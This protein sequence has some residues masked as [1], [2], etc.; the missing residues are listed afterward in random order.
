MM[1]HSQQGAILV[2]GAAGFIGSHVSQALVARNDLVI[3]LDNFDPYYDPSLKRENLTDLL[4]SDTFEFV[5][6]DICDQRAVQAVFARGV[7]SVIHLAAKAGVRPSLKDPLAYANTNVAGTIRLLEAARQAGV[8]RFVFG[9]SSSVYGAANHVPFSEDQPIQRPVSP[10]A[11]S[12]VAGEAFCHTCHHLYGVPVMCLRLFTVYG[13]RQRPDLAI[14]KFV[15]LLLAGEPI[16]QYGDGSSSRDYTFIED[17]VRGILAAHDSDL[18][19]EVINLGSSSPIRLDAMIR[20]VAEAVGVEPRIQQLP[21]QPGDVP[22]TYASVEKAKRLL[23]W[24]PQWDLVAGL[25]EFIKW[26][27]RS[28]LRAHGAG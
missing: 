17:I 16:P 4:K 14:N 23:S 12:K 9:S 6:G 2:T 21:D 28:R 22:R 11:A 15:R 27:K 3:G 26:H 8:Q 13:P 25:T 24:Q 19:Y 1:S 7:S 5:E 10:Y 20:A 18:E